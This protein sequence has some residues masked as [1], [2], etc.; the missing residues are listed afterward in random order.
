MTPGIIYC[1]QCG[2]KNEFGERF[3]ANCGVPLFVSPPPF[4]PSTPYNPSA[5]HRVPSQ[6]SRSPLSRRSGSKPWIIFVIFILGL[7]CCCLVLFFGL[8]LIDF[9]NLDP[10]LFTTVREPSPVE[11]EVIGNL[12]IT[13]DGGTFMHDGLEISVHPGAVSSPVTLIINREKTSP[14][15]P[16]GFAYQSRRFGFE[17]DFQ[18]IN[19]DIEIKITVPIDVIPSDF[20]GGEVSIMMEEPIYA[21]SAGFIMLQRPLTTQID[22]A[23]GVLTTIFRPES[24]TAFRPAF[25]LASMSPK[26]NIDDQASLPQK[27]IVWAKIL[28]VRNIYPTTFSNQFFNLNTYGWIND[29][30]GNQILALLTEQ[31]ELLERNNAQ[32]F[33]ARTSWP[34]NIYLGKTNPYLGLSGMGSIDGL[35]RPSSLGINYADIL[36]N[37]DNLVLNTPDGIGNL[38]AILGH[39]LFHLV[40]SGYDP[41]NAFNRRKNPEQVIWSDEAMATWFESIATGDDSF[42]PSNIDTNCDSI[43][44]PMFSATA[45]EIA[46]ASPNKSYLDYLAIDPELASRYLVLTRRGYAN[47]MFLRYL[48]KGFGDRLPMEIL[49]MEKNQSTGLGDFSMVRVWD[50]ALNLYGT[51]LSKE[52]PWFLE[53][54][55]LNPKQGL[56]Y[57]DNF[58]C[59]IKLVPTSKLTALVDVDTTSEDNDYILKYMSSSK[60][61]IPFTTFTPHALKNDGIPAKA[62]IK[63]PLRNFSAFPFMLDIQRDAMT[64]ENLTGKMKTVINVSCTGN[65]GTIDCASILG[66]LLYYIPKDSLWEGTISPTPVD[67]DKNGY[68][69]PNSEMSSVTLSS[70]LFGPGTDFNGLIFIPFN[71]FAATSGESDVSSIIIDI[72][73]FYGGQEQPENFSCS[74]LDAIY[75]IGYTEISEG[76]TSEYSDSDYLFKDKMEIKGGFIWNPDDKV[77]EV[78]ADFSMQVEP[79]GPFELADSGNLFFTQCGAWAKCN[80]ENTEDNCPFTQ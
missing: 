50:K 26:F 74:C 67:Y 76:T 34:I 70:A 53:T 32:A 33:K 19:G 6:S 62:Q 77:C 43:R 14:T 18:K 58:M 63:I 42:L 22:L 57:N 7:V 60:D 79:E 75:P 9:L 12:N 20:G 37:F 8:R 51:N 21:P 38:K 35:F 65:Q 41:R 39:E 52:Y 80:G 45:V 4:G 31:K 10:G 23:S 3:C 47:S 72:E 36:I 17:G 61:L 30:S 13:A 44:Q 54:L 73:I 40:Q 56:G 5:R 25:H 28:A 55:F 66:V 1:S 29:K 69:V 48:T 68:I 16:Q 59:P 49:E 24:P 27:M 78:P 46:A 15:L 2:H 64:T 11:M 71:N